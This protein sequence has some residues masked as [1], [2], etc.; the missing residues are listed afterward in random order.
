LILNIFYLFYFYILNLINF[1]E[2]GAPKHNFTIAEEAVIRKH[3]LVEVESVGVNLGSKYYENTK[4]PQLIEADSKDLPVKNVEVLAQVAK[5][6]DRKPEKVEK[7]E[8]KIE[9]SKNSL[10]KYFIL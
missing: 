9:K 4:K 5:S 3:N 1:F 2:E 10:V 8:I 6:E 7:T